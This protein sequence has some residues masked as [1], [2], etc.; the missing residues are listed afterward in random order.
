MECD[1]TGRRV[2]SIRP[3]RLGIVEAID[4]FVEGNL[5]LPSFMD[6]FSAAALHTEH[7]HT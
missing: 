5:R 4:R 1:A 6:D 7:Q 2:I 3:S